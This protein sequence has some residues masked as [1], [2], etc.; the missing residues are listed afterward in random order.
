MDGR[1]VRL[2]KDKKRDAEI[3]EELFL[4]T[5]SRFPTDKEK[6]AAK[7]ALAGEEKRG[8]ALQDVFWALLNSKPFV[9]N[10]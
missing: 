5:Y 3:I 7:A 2:I 10:R 1:L 4:A 6:A 8:D 9:F